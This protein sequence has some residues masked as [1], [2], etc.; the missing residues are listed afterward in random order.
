MKNEIQKPKDEIKTKFK[1]PI[2]IGT[3]KLERSKNEIRNL[4]ETSNYSSSALA[5]AFLI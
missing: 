1:I 2:I 4:P 3:G 5:S